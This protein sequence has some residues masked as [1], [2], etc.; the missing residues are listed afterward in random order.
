MPGCGQIIFFL[1]LSLLQKVNLPQ[2]T[3]LI[4]LADR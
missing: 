3:E 2:I 4:L 1:K